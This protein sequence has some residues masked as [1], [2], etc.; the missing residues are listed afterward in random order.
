MAAYI[1]QALLNQIAQLNALPVAPQIR[2]QIVNVVNQLAQ[3]VLANQA[4]PNQIQQLQAQVVHINLQLDVAQQNINAQ[5]AAN[6][7]LAAANAGLVQANAGYAQANA[8]LA[9]VNNQQAA[10][11]ANLIALVNQRANEIQAANVQIQAQIAIAANI[12]RIGEIRDIFRKRIAYLVFA[13]NRCSKQKWIAVGSIIFSPV[14]LFK[15]SDQDELRGKLRNTRAALVY[16]NGLV[17][18]HVGGEDAFTRTKNAYS[19]ANYELAHCD[20]VLT[21]GSVLFRAV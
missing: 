11:L 6:V 13:E 17:A 18:Q 5:V 3:I 4:N 1:P 20:Y 21:D 19:L 2:A 8:Q 12:A 16:F 9:A 7:Q 15:W 14:A 10:N